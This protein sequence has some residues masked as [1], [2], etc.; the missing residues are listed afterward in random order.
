MPSGSH[1]TCQ[2][3]EA[4]FLVSK[5]QS[6]PSIIRHL[7]W[8]CRTESSRPLLG[9]LGSRGWDL[10]KIKCYQ[11]LWR[12]SSSL[13]TF[14]Q[15]TVT[16]WGIYKIPKKIQYN[17]FCQLDNICYFY[18]LDRNLE[19]PMPFS[20]ISAFCSYFYYFLWIY[21]YLKI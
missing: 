11:T 15:F 4:Q 14:P 16:F 17:S 10:S 1:Q 2:N 12:F 19:F 13:L 9:K 3:E 18:W 20:L 5:F 6:T 21:D 8:E 7:Y